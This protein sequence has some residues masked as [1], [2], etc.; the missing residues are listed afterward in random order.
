MNKKTVF[1]ISC[2]MLGIVMVYGQVDPVKKGLDVLSPQNSRAIL[3]FLSSDWM[4]G[5]EPGTKRH[6]LAAEYLASM[7]QLNGLEPIKKLNDP[8]SQADNMYFPNNDYYQNF[9][10]LMLNEFM[11]DYNRNLDKI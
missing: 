11:N 6:D 7:F 4:E 10:L 3:T 8:F 1:T 5:R 2:Y 9:P